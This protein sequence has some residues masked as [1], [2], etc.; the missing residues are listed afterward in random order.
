MGLLLYPGNR[1]D[2]G[3]SPSVE[4]QATAYNAFEYVITSATK[5]HWRQSS[6]PDTHHDIPL[7]G[8]AAT[9]EI[10]ADSTDTYIVC[11]TLC[12]TCIEACC[13]FNCVDLNESFDCMRCWE[14]G[15]LLPTDFTHVQIT[16][17]DGGITNSFIPGDPLDAE[18]CDTDC[19][20]WS[21]TYI[22]DICN[23]CTMGKFSFICTTDDGT[24]VVDW[25]AYTYLQIY[26]DYLSGYLRV[27]IHQGAGGV[28]TST[29]GIPTGYPPPEDFDCGDFFDG[30]GLLLP[31]YYSTIHDWIWEQDVVYST[32]V[33]TGEETGPKQICTILPMTDEGM[34]VIPTAGCTNIFNYTVTLDE[35]FPL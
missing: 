2:P 11:A 15:T 20:D 29:G 8:G 26:W 28:I 25:Y 21:G 34:S 6:D 18:E 3:S 9:G 32:N 35:I 23:P 12:A 22:V 31:L 24:T 17:T 5:A 7:V 33:C 16:I 10:F 19:P 1:C 4:C 14:E 30:W 27:R 13:T